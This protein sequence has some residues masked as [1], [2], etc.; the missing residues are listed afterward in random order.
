MNDLMECMSLKYFGSIVTIQAKKT[1]KFLGW[2]NCWR[3]FNEFRK[4]A[5]I[6]VVSDSNVNSPTI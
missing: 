3:M 1:S 2:R 6:L 4:S 5:R